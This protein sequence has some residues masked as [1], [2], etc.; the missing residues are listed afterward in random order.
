LGSQIEYEL[1]TDAGR[2]PAGRHADEGGG[3]R[4]ERER[5]RQADDQAPLAGDY[6]VVDDLAVDERHGR[7]DPGVGQDQ[8]DE[9]DQP[10]AVAA[11]VGSDAAHRPPSELVRGDRAVTAEARPGSPPPTLSWYQHA[12]PG[13]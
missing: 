8:Q 3:H 12:P 11:G 6:A 10:S 2:V 7:P 9:D 5:H 4:Q 13:T 1:L